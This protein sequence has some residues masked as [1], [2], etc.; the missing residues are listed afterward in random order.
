MFIN[1][2]QTVLL[3]KPQGTSEMLSELSNFVIKWHVQDKMNLG[4]TLD[5]DASNLQ[6][7]RMSA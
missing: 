4:E 5:T 6:S 1:S 3:A 2:T 7:W